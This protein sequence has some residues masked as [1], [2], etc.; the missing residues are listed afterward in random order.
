MDSQ[1][2]IRGHQRRTAETSLADIHVGTAGYSY[3]HWRKGEFYPQAGVTQAQELRHYSGVFPAVEINASFHGVPREE[4]LKNWDE[5]AK[6]G[7]LFSFKVPKEI[8]HEK[9]LEDIDGPWAF[10]LERLGTIKSRLGPILFQLPPSLHKNIDKLDVIRKLTPP[11]IKIAF[12]FRNKSWY[13]DD[14]FETLR[15]NDMGLCEN[16]SPDNSTLHS[17]ETTAGTWHYIRFHKQLENRLETNYTDQQLAEIADRLVLRRQSNIVQYCYFLNDHNGNGPRNAKT[18]MKFVLDRS[19]KIPFVKNWEPDPV[20]K[21]IQ[22]FFSKSRNSSAASTP[23][24]SPANTNS[25]FPASSKRRAGRSIDSFFSPADKSAKRPKFKP[26]QCHTQSDK[27]SPRNK[28]TI[29]SFF[30]K[31]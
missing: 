21:S 12:E 13:C 5:K 24:K 1:K 16:I 26:T 22:S 25:E 17:L 18:L 7:F 15:R 4:T 31:T 10:F 30:S 19:Q 28:R 6:T 2:T 11:V 9:R 29:T 8:T 3:S 14:V 20:A 23:R 27:K